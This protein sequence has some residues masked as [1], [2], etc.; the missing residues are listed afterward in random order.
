[1]RS[2]APAQW[3][4]IGKGIGNY[5]VYG[6]FTDQTGDPKTYLFPAGRILGRDPAKVEAVDHQKI[7][8]SVAH[9][10]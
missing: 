2:R 7:T 8:E 9:S 3:F 4:S 6:D 5:M 10:Y 1:L